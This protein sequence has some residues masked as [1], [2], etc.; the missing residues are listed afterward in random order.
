MFNK[1]DSA[2]RRGAG[3]YPT[4]LSGMEWNPQA[5]SLSIRENLSLSGRYQLPGI[6][7]KL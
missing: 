3:H 6:Y 2:G 7:K 5:R 4:E 1:N